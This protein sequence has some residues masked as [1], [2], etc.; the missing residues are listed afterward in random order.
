MNPCVVC[1]RAIEDG[2]GVATA[3]SDRWKH[4]VCP[5]KVCKKKK[6]IGTSRWSDFVP[7]SRDGKGQTDEGEWLCGQHMGAYRRVKKNDAARKEKKSRDD[8]NQ[9]R[10]T[11]ALNILA[12]LEV[13]GRAHYTLNPYRFTGKIIVDPA[14]LFK[15]IGIGA[16]LPDIQE[17]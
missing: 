7:C 11:M 3:S 6:N 13:P 4:T 14:D 9:Q 8:A 10:S 15:A 5:E 16:T 12:E 1:G 2:E 17:K